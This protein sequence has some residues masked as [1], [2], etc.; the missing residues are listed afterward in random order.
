MRIA[1]ATLAGLVLGVSTAVAAQGKYPDKPIRLIVPVA[2]GGGTDFIARLLGQKLNE[3][4]GEPVIVDNRPGAAGNLGVE[5]AAKAVPDGY[6][7]VIPITSFPINPSLYAKLP[8]DTVRDFAPITL[9]ASAPL[10]LVVNPKLQ[11]NS[12]KELIALAK[13]KPGALNFANSGSGTTAHLAGEMFK[14][15][16]GVD[17]V[18]VPYKGGGPAVIDLLAGNVQMYFSTIPAALT[19]VKAGRLRALAVTGGK[20]MSEISDIP[21]VSES[22]LAGFEVVAWFGMFAPARTPQ[23]VVRKLN[24]ELV[25]IL[26]TSEVREKMAG[27]GLIPGGNTPEQLGSFLKA[28]IAKWS[29]V[30]KDADIRIP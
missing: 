22:G 11:A 18:S 6:T 5:I 23:P 3:A 26:N 25:R 19:Q 21:T 2:P 1:G 24:T 28:E 13:A 8:F 10:L 29:Q 27:H 16:A 7:L 14:R 15:M 17:I 20:R 4:W 30:I 12:V 9:V